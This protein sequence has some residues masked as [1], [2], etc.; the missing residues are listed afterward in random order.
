MKLKN[1][2]FA[3]MIACAFASCSEDDAVIDNGPV[4]K[5]DTSFTV[6][7]TAKSTKAT[8]AGVDD[9]MQNVNVVLL[10][11]GGDAVVRKV[12][13]PD[14]NGE[15]TFDDLEVGTVV[16]AAAFANFGRALND[17]EI[18]G[19]TP[20][21][22]S[23][24]KG[25]YV[26]DQIPMHGAAA[27]TVEVKA[28]DNSTAVEL[29]R[30]LAKVELTGVALDMNG[31]QNGKAYQTDF[32]AG[33]VT[34]KL[35]SAAINSAAESVTFSGLGTAYTTPTTWVGGMSPW[36][37]AKKSVSNTTQLAAYSISATSDAVTQDIKTGDNTDIKNIAMDKDKFVYYVI[38]NAV[39][40][41]PTVLTLNADFA[42]K[43]GVKNGV[44]INDQTYNAFY[45]IEIG[46][47]N[48][49]FDTVDGNGKY[50]KGSGIVANKHYKIQ[51]TVVGNGDGETGSRPTLVVAMT[52]ADWDVVD[53]GAV[54]Q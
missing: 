49:D 3:T 11:A 8:N 27:A 18:L 51:A 13:L 4:A 7:L 17:D 21:Q 44:N 22:L 38:P 14:T 34:F 29:V 48:S 25:L 19:K 37:W 42:I 43:G 30:D 10:N 31:S 41:Q 32:T 1:F 54:V 45:N 36:T 33:K 9:N 53:Q 23:V 12:Y 15:Y 26:A 46:Q 2:M 20:I 50:T 35:K 47:S 39:A 16:K 24:E 6:S 40:T 28:G 5:G 52:V